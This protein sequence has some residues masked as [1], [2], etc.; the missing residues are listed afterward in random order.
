MYE[1]VRGYID[2]N[3]QVKSVMSIRLFTVSKRLEVSPMYALPQEQ[4][5]REW[6]SRCFV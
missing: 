5:G 4:G 3:I 2:L 1:D 6:G